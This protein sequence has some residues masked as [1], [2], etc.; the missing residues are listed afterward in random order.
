MDMT[1]DIVQMLLKASQQQCKVHA[2][3]YTV[4]FNSNSNR[5]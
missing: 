2:S 1:R 4:D 5:F 3:I